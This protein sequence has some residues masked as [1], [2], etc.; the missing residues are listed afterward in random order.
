MIGFA[1]RC[2]IG[3]LVG[4]VI[5]G[6]CAGPGL[7]PTPDINATVQAAIGQ[8]RTVEAAV[9]IAVAA[10][11]QAQQSAPDPPPT[12]TPVPS[13]TPTLPPTA[14]PAPSPTPTSPPTATPTPTE[15]RLVIAESAVDGSN[16]GGKDIL[17]SSSPTNFGRVILLPGFSQSQVTSPMLFRDDFTMRVAVFD[18]RRSGQQDGNGIRSVTFELSGPNGLTFRKV[19]NT[20]PYCLFG[21]SDPACPGVD[22][23]QA[24]ADWFSGQYQAAITIEATD[25]LTS[26]WNWGFCIR[27]CEAT[28]PP[29]VE[30]AEIGRNSLS[31][32]L[33]GQLV[34]R[35]TAYQESVGY[36]DGDGIDHVDFYIFGPDDDFNRIYYKRENIA[37]YCAFG[38]D[39]P[40]N[41]AQINEPGEYRLLAIAT[42]D[43]GQQAPV[44][45]WIDVQ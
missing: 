16:G 14:T 42:A 29:I 1:G 45:A 11:S 2:A 37:A 7:Q 23:E 22:L 28:E 21:G 12:A 15:E 31:Y 34:F 9:A 40:C 36:D 32:S 20:A 41:G 13:P 43:D 6:A 17:V 35:V 24:S 25:G 33:S 27:Y 8:T 4:I 5:L 19:E 39:V 3:W 44:E 26:N 10:T 18:T 38:D 30:L